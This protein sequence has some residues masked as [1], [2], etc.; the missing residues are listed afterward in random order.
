METLICARTRKGSGRSGR[1]D[2]T[3]APVVSPQIPA[4]A[5]VRI[6]RNVWKSSRLPRPFPP[7]MTRTTRGMRERTRGTQSC[8][9]RRGRGRGDRRVVSAPRLAHLGTDRRRDPRR[10]RDDDDD[11]G[12]RF[13][14]GTLVLRR[15]SPRRDSDG[16][17]RSRA[18]ADGPVER[19]V[20]PRGFRSFVPFFLQWS[21][22]KLSPA[23]RRRR[24]R[25]RFS[26][27]EPLRPAV[28][29][30]EDMDMDEESVLRGSGW[31]TR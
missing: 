13:R 15:G 2:S 23:S 27:R 29:G 26:A 12:Q 14:P 11:A 7:P 6:P 16:T 3:R 19:R 24:H 17:R 9:R 20:P 25:R 21:P 5:F 28:A 1:C 30:P 4:P 8:S 31:R 10:D 18:R 22:D